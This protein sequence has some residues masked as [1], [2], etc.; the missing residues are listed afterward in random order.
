MQIK[1]D[2]VLIQSAKDCKAEES[3]IYILPHSPFLSLQHTKCCFHHFLQLPYR[4]SPIDIAG[5]SLLVLTFSNHSIVTILMYIL[6]GIL[7]FFLF[8]FPY[9]FLFFSFIEICEVC[10]MTRCLSVAVSIFCL[11]R[12]TSSSCVIVPV[13]SM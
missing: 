4:L 6:L 8:C 10:D 13:S 3:L 11:Q 7:L 12:R 1:N 9:S 2:S 5:A